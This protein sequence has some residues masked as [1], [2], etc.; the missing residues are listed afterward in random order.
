MKHTLTDLTASIRGFLADE[1]RVM[2]KIGN[3]KR[4]LDL[5]CGRGQ[6]SY[7]L[8]MAFPDAEVVG[9]DLDADR[10][11]RAKQRFSAPNLTYVVADATGYRSKKQFDAIVAVDVFHHVPKNMHAKMLKGIRG[12]LRKNGLLVVVDINPSSPL[13]IFNTLHDRLLN[14]LA[15]QSYVSDSKWKKCLSGFEINRIEHSIRLVYPRTY[16]VAKRV[17]GG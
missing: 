12:N 15:K 14:G 4:I 1:R 6:F 8:A 3:A 11:A 2:Q 9:A 10:I 16:V 17:S 7:S 13:S 5:G